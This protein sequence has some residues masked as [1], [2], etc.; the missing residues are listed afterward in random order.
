MCQGKPDFLGRTI[1][2]PQVNLDASQPAPAILQ[3]YPVRKGQTG[4]GE[5][6]FAAE[7]YLVSNDRCVY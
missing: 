5:V 7:L 2:Y 4:G 3:W 1:T 6:L